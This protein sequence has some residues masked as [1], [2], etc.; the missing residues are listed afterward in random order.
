ML[1]MYTSSIS[2][3]WIE[4]IILCNS[5]RVT[6][7]TKRYLINNKVIADTIPLMNLKIGKLTVD[8]TIML[9][10]IIFVDS[11]YYYCRN[12]LFENI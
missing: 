8:P 1:K 12:K 4:I 3:L 9:L 6:V 7:L 10:E 11:N 2:G 5:M